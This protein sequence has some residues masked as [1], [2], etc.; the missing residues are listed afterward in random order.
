MKRRMRFSTAFNVVARAELLAQKIVHLSA[1][2]T[3][4]GEYTQALQLAET[5]DKNF[6]E[7]AYTS[8]D[9]A[10]MALSGLDQLATALRMRGAESAEV[11]AKISQNVAQ[12]FET[13]EVVV[14]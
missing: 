3:G 4:A 1:N 8:P 7:G 9:E 12:R 2:E 14:H 10:F 13:P 6:F 11:V 5:I